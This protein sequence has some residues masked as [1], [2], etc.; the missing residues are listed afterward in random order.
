MKYNK[1]LTH[2]DLSGWGI[3]TSMAKQIFKCLKN[4]MSLQTVHLDG[5][6]FVIDTSAPVAIANLIRGKINYVDN[7][8]KKRVPDKMDLEINEEKAYLNEIKKELK[9]INIP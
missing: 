7:Y 6:P 8:K 9:I 4:A 1:E 5:N 2:L 3:T